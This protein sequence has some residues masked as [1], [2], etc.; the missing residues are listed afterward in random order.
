MARRCRL[1]L[2]MLLSVLTTALLALP[3]TTAAFTPTCQNGVGHYGPT[4]C[5]SL[6]QG[7]CYVGTMCYSWDCVITNGT[8]HPTNVQTHPSFISCYYYSACCG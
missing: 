2:L 7:S 4:S 8:L 6:Y 5:H 3:S 1:P